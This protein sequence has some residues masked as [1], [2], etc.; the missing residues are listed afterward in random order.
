MTVSFH[1][2]GNFFPGTGDIVDLGAGSGKYYAV[3]VPLNDGVDDEQFVNLFKV[4]LSKCIERFLPEAIVLQCGADS[5][6]GD[7]IGN[8]NLSTKGHGACVEFIKSFKIPLMLLGGGGYTIR[9]VAR[10]WLYETAIALDSNVSNHIPLN[11]YIEYF[12]P[13]YNLH[14]PNNPNLVNQNPN[15]YIEKVKMKILQHL[16]NLEHAPSEFLLH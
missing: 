14:L 5:I 16:S 7:R 3:N 8:F 12:G 6:T 10:A 1:K 13:Q 4:V 9:N 2:F 11:E 15:E